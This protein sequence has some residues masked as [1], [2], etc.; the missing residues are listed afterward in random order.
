MLPKPL[1]KLT[2]VACNTVRM[3]VTPTTTRPV[4]IVTTLFIDLSPTSTIAPDGFVSTT[5][6][7]GA[8]VGVIG[9]VVGAGVGGLRVGVGGSQGGPQLI[10]SSAESRII[11]TRLLYISPILPPIQFTRHDKLTRYPP[12]VP[13]CARLGVQPNGTRTQQ[14]CGI[15]SILGRASTPR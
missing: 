3:G 10:N 11:A 15:D 12:P 14:D 1:N 13:Y 6:I 2:S 8:G 9:R 7:A 4:P 5:R